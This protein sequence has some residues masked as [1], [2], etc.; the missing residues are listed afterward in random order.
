M[1]IQVSEFGI[2][3][4]GTP[5]TRVR[6]SND[7]L[8]VSLLSLGARVQDVRLTGVP[9]PLTLGSESLMSYLGA[10][11]FFGVIVG[12]VA[13]RI[14]NGQVKSGD[15]VFQLPLHDGPYALHS[16]PSGTHE[17][18]W[19]IKAQGEDVVE[20]GLSLPHGACGLPGERQFRAKFTL[21]GATLGL[22]LTATTTTRTPINLANHSY[23]NLD[24]TRDIRGH[25]LRVAGDAILETND[26]ILPTGQLAAVKGT[27]FDHR[28]LSPFTPSPERRYDNSYCVAKA[29]RDLSE[30]AQLRGQKGVS[31]RMATTEPGLQVFDAGTIDTGASIG[32][33]GQPYHP[34]CGVA[35]EAQGWPDATSQ[36]DFPSIW[37]EPGETYEQVTQWHFARDD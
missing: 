11:D 3:P 6:L 14:S 4:D 31:M 15:Q 1:A 9:W 36:P 25:H 8:S 16:G 22:T 27:Y 35:L 30:V 18:V 12:P 28:A 26:A 5:V 21:S 34:F 23:W 24:G 2:M 13:N 10:M 7:S 33:T 32:L 37:L 19:Q 17:Q 20:M 29:R